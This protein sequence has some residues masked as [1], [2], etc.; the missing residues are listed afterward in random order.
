[1][2][3]NMVINMI[4]TKTLFVGGNFDDKTGKKSKIAEIVAQ[5]LV[6]DVSNTFTNNTNILPISNTSLDITYYNGGNLK[7]LENIVQK[8]QDYKII[9]WFPN[10]SNNEQKLVKKL[11]I[12]NPGHVLVTSKNNFENKYGFGDLV[13]HALNNHSNLFVE[14]TKDKAEVKTGE[15][16]RIRGRIIDPLGNVFLNYCD[17]FHLVSQVLKERSVELAEY[18]RMP[19]FKLHEK[20]DGS[21]SISTSTQILTPISTHESDYFLDIV[22]RY[23]NRFHELIHP[24][25]DAE[26][27]FM[28]NASFR[29]TYG[30]PSARTGNGIMV[31]RRNIDKR[32]LNFDSFVFVKKDWPVEYYGNFKPSVD[33]PVQIGLYNY[34]PNVNYMIH[35]HTY[36]E[37]A[38]F[39]RNV[40]PCGALEEI[41]DIADLF[42]DNNSKDFSVNL[43]GHGS[44]VLASS[45]SHLENIQYYSKSLP[46][47][48]GD[49]KVRA[50]K[51]LEAQK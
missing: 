18:V 3:S 50:R 30:F 10:I 5:S 7:E 13:Y 6:N 45:V 32:E 8:C 22:K 49:Y 46:E 2:T 42:P 20:Y 33:T 26:T 25:E 43:R 24:K 17:D 34:Y 51:S 14:F 11:K 28:G 16:A 48:H 47:I 44:I 35:S 39:T 23:A 36:I 9:F 15:T 27:R 19:S 38:P 4:K 41:T 12:I 40:I 29:C 21:N 1:M 31:S 37:N